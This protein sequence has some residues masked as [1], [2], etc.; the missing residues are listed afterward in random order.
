MS[1]PLGNLQMED[2]R[3]WIGN[4]TGMFTVKSAYCIAQNILEPNHPEESSVGDPYQP[5]WKKNLAHEN[6]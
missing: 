2:T 1:I 3:V 6:P 5:L 4:S